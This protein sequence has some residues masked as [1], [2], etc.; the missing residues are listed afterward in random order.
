MIEREKAL[1]AERVA[2]RLAELGDALAS[3]STH[4]A[5]DLASGL[6]PRVAVAAC[7]ECWIVAIQ[8]GEYWSEPPPAAVIFHARRAARG[9]VSL[10]RLLRGYVEG[11]DVLWRAT[12]EEIERLAPSETG[13]LRRQTWA[14]TESLLAC[15]LGAVED[16]YADE[17][18]RDA[19]TADERQAQLVRRLIKGDRSVD[20]RLIR[21]DFTGTHLAVIA[22]GKGSALRAL[23]TLAVHCGG[24]LFGL[25]EQ[26]GVLLAWVRLARR[27]LRP[28]D[29]ERYLPAARYPEITLAIGRSADGLHGFCST[30]RLAA[31]ALM[32][33]R[34]RP[35]RVTWH[36][37]VEL[38]AL[39]LR[40]EPFAKGLIAH[41]LAPLKPPLRET[42]RVYVQNQSPTVTGVALGVNRNTIS[43]RLRKIEQTIGRPLSECHFNVLLA[44]HADELGITSAG[45]L[46][47]H[48]N[49]KPGA[50]LGFAPQ[51][52]A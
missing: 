48:K 5:I 13:V 35:A 8:R 33:A 36:A 30:Y 10:A 46:T 47:A 6:D 15:V 29:V 40:D 7:L 43:A 25:P 45:T 38:D 31:E 19:Q 24:T 34:R 21:H 44:V 39:L 17:Q 3:G 2:S 9:G 50:A 20:V 12:E 16:A 18:R 26:D 37:D 49:Q 28:A 27:E 51:N 11:R 32:V 14:A 1:L 42:L 41:Y 52:Q 22:A 23:Q 4:V